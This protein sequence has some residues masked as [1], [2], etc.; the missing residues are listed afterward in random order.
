MKVLS[1]ITEAKAR[2]GNSR[3]F[4]INPHLLGSGR[5]AQGTTDVASFTLP[6]QRRTWFKKLEDV[7]TNIRT[8]FGL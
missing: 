6:G 2:S 8:H 3:I 1:N 5:L 7:P 4:P